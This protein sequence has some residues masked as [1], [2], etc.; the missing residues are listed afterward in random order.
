MLDTSWLAGTR[1]YVTAENLLAYLTDSELRVH[2]P[3]ADQTLWSIATSEN[4]C[5][6]GT[7]RTLMWV[8]TPD[9][10]FQQVGDATNAMDGT[11]TQ[12]GEVTITF[13]PEDPDQAQTTGYGLL[14]KVDGEWR[15]EMQMATGATALALHWAYM[16]PWMGAE[17]PAGV[18]ERA[19]EGSLR[20]EEWRWLRGTSWTATDEELFPDGATFA[21]DSYRNGYFWGE[22]TTADGSGLR[23][24]GSVTPEGAV[25]ITFVRQGARSGGSAGRRRCRRATA[26]TA[27]AGRPRSRPRT[28][29]HRA[30]SR[31]ARNV[32]PAPFA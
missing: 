30:A 1:W 12:G 10:T 2:T 28:R 32:R 16:T 3:V 22:G 31:L 24:A 20:S 23:I 26:A 7:A 29:R 21:I 19:L 11:I 8:R 5:F 4:G 14:R 6:T 25:Y 15:M 9:G 17:P 18:P 27:R 13:T